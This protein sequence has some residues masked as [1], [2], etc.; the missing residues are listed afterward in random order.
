LLRARLQPCHKD[1]Q[2]RRALAPEGN[3]KGRS[4]ASASQKE[5]E[6]TK[7]INKENMSS[8]AQQNPEPESLLATGTEGA[9]MRQLAAE[10]LAAHRNRRAQNQQAQILQDR[11]DEQTAVRL[12]ARRDRGHDENHPAATRVRDAVAARYQQTVTYQ[13]FLAAEAERALQQARAEAEVAARNAIAVAE[14]QRQLLADI[15]H[16]NRP[17]VQPVLLEVVPTAA[18][19]AE[20]APA[21]T[22]KPTSAELPASALL[23][24]QLFADI[25]P[26]PLAPAFTNAIPQH[27]HAVSDAMAELDQE[28][29]FR[30]APE[31]QNHVLETSPI[32]ANIIEFP[33]Q[34]VASRKARPRL[35]E[36][37][38]REDGTPEPQLRIFE[39]EP[40][41]ISVEPAFVYAAEHT[42]PAPEWQGLLL[43]GSSAENAAAFAAA[44]AAEL[45]AETALYAAPISLRLMATAVDTL[46]L[47]GAF[48]GFVATV[49]RL[50]GPALRSTPLPLLG[51]AAAGSLIFFAIL[52]RLLFFTLNEATPGMRY[53]RLAFCTFQE[54]SPRR[55]A[56]RRRMFSTALALTPLGLGLLW[57]TMDGDRLGWHD[58]LSRMY[59]RHY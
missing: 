39:V 8:A 57:M 13:Q 34:L 25:P 6:R 45:L 31:F 26:S 14:A 36:G 28:I 20:A 3:V 16:W 54:S 40:E 41:Q 35:A 1:R 22:R 23:K 52:Y 17:E 58:R 46:T 55:S 27:R 2:Q 5:F 56:I 7:R 42:A 15:E 48:L 38:L 11:I 9:P 30:L 12:Q 21:P 19:P 10:K 51:G 53:A 4:N 18:A 49:A 24:V 32:Q 43:S 33:R 47:L 50:A 59:P 37:P 44:P 29:A